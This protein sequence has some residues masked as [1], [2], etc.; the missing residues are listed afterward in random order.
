MAAA[1]VVSAGAHVVPG[2][3][4]CS[5]RRSLAGAEASNGAS[6]RSGTAGPDVAD[7]GSG[8]RS[9]AA[10]GTRSTTRRKRRRPSAGRRSMPTPRASIM[11]GDGRGRAHPHLAGAGRASASGRRQPAA[12]PR[13]SGAAPGR[14][15]P[16]PEGPRSRTPAGAKATAVP[17]M[18]C[19]GLEFIGRL[20]APLLKQSQWHDGP[21]IRRGLKFSQSIEWLSTETPL[22][23]RNRL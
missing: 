20:G 12:R 21:G 4:P 14:I 19:L 7:R 9:I 17:W 16:L 8:R 1:S 13:R 2:A 23:Y 11:A 18:R 10:A 22:G 3:G 15:C 5:A 6:A